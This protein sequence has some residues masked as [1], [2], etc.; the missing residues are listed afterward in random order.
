M[1]VCIL[2]NVEE[3][4]PRVHPELSNK[5]PRALTYQSSAKDEEGLT[6]YADMITETIRSLD[7]DEG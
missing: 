7:K 2:V 4:K 6:R 3:F 1:L 5:N